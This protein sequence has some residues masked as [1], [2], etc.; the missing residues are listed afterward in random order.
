MQLTNREITEIDWLIRQQLMTLQ[1]NHYG[2]LTVKVEGD[3]VSDIV[4]THQTDRAEIK[5]AQCDLY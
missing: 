4:L 5:K 1:R 3:K 2:N